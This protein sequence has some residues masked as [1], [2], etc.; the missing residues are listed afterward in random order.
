MNRLAPLVALLPLV[1]ACSPSRPSGTPAGH[2][3]YGGDTAFESTG[4]ASPMAPAAAPPGD[5]AK[6]AAPTAEMSDARG[7]AMAPESEARPGL[8]TEWGETMSSRVSSAPF[9]RSEAE[10][11]F[12]VAS[13]F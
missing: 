11:P 9:E 6:S 1:A 10:R 12:S 2:A 4:S 8:G 3:P 13:L 5:M 7:G